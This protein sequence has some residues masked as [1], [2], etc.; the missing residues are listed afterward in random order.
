LKRE[1]NMMYE[2]NDNSVGDD[3]R[4]ILNMMQNDNGDS[5]LED[6][7]NVFFPDQGDSQYS[8]SGFP[9]PAFANE[10]SARRNKLPKY[11]ISPQNHYYRYTINH[12]ISR[13]FGISAPNCID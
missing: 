8:L 11:I 1:K 10:L 2:S 12:I 5:F 4:N 6:R 9:L 3:E 13:S 7:R